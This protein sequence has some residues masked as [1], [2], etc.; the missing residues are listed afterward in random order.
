MKKN[1]YSDL[2]LDQT[3]DLFWA[4]DQNLY[5]VYANRAYLDLMREVTGEEKKLNTPIL[6]EGFGEGYIK[7]WKAYYQRALSGEHFEIE[8]HFYN[9]ETKGMQYGHIAF[10]PIR[11]EDGKILTVAC[12]SADITPVIRQKD[13]ASRLLNASLDVF[14]TIDESGN[15]V[16]V[17]AASADHWGYHP[18]ELIGKP[19]RDLIVE[20]DLEITDRVAAEILGGR[21]FKSFSNRYRKKNGISPIICG[22]PA[23]MPNP[24]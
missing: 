13:H 15:F 20:E 12:R 7:K 18:E 14:C 23:G 3:K 5:L 8:E 9:P 22:R 19:Y 2:L 24:T 4:V 16:Y 10:S 1:Q 17:S 21:E 11:E 6:V